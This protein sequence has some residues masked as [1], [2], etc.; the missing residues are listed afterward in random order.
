MFLGFQ[1]SARAAQGEGFSSC[2]WGIQKGAI[3]SGDI[4]YYI[5]FFFFSH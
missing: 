3:K 5:I 4:K 1:L 2:I